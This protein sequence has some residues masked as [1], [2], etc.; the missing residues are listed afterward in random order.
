VVINK[1]DGDNIEKAK[2]ARKDYENALH[3]LKPASPVWTPP[4][5][6]CSA[7]EMTGV[8]DV[9]ETVL[10]HHELMTKSCELEQ[11]RRHQSLAWMWSLVEEGLK[12]RFHQHPEVQR[13][14]PQLSRQVENGML[15]SVAAA[16]QLLFFLDN[17]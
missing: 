16:C 3:L 5:L 11:N 17:P 14:L 8:S 2:R 6:T 10:R 1:A 4:V 9:W 13:R 15:S 12:Q 7:R